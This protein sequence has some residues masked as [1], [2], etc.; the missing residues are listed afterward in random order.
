[1]KIKFFDTTLRDGT[2]ASGISLSVD[3]KLKIAKALDEFG[4]HYIEGGW[5][6]SNKTDEL[7]F[8]KAKESLKLK[9][10]QLTAFGS[11]RYKG[12]RAQNDPNLRSIANSRVKVACIFG[13]SW[14]LHVAHALRVSLEENLK[15]IE[16]SIKYLRSKSIEVIYDAEHFFDGFCANKKYALETIK[17]AARAGAVNVTLCDTNGGTLPDDIRSIILVVKNEMAGA[18]LLTD[19]GIHTHNDSDCAV[20][21]TICAVK[22]GVRL[23]QG[24]INGYGERCGNADLCSVIPNLQLKLG[25]KCISDKKLKLLTELSRY[26]SEVANKLPDEH[27]PY[28]GYSAFAHKGGIHVSAVTR[29]T[30]TYEHVNPGSVGNERRILVSELAGKSNIAVKVKELRL[31]F[32]QDIESTKKIFQLIKKLEHQGY[33]FEDA[34]ASFALTVRRAFKKYKSFFDVVG[35]RAIVERNPLTGKM[36]SEAT[37]KINVG[38][39]EEHT[40]AE[41]DGPVNALDN[42]LRKAL[43]RFFPELKEVSLSDFKVRVISA[44]EGTASKVR[45][46]IESRD[47]NEIWG[48]IG[49]SEN[50][51]EASWQALVDAIEYKL[52][53]QRG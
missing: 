47:R 22:E 10:A 39:K 1:M 8:K 26:V 52:L 18:K 41:G 34:N 19:L 51:I 27:R 17:V 16:D 12:N 5:P 7:F 53:K 49:V 46:I 9:R 36:R 50:I 14:D 31:D 23:V 37:I 33:Q 11:T 24:T 4:I 44:T 2:Q 30:A 32:A 48:T 25:I 40:V 29:H 3:D 28:V 20:A 42:A 21:N 38:G 45:V 43:E 15:M 6:G 35:F 13:K